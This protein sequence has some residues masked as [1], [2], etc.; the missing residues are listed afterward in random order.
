[1]KRYI[2]GKK[3]PNHAVSGDNCGMFNKIILLCGCLAI[4]MTPSAAMAKADG[5]SA[6]SVAVQATSTVR[7]HSGVRVA[8][9]A[10]NVGTVHVKGSKSRMD[11]S[12]WR[13]PPTQSAKAGTYYVDFS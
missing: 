11:I 6:P 5:A 9:T 3:L 1:M 2:H 4:A 12:K 8:W 10:D 7:V 13:K